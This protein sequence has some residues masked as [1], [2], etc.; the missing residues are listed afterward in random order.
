M[1]I[2]VLVNGN[3]PYFLPPHFREFFA[4]S[5]RLLR[6][7][8]KGQARWLIY[9]RT[10]F[11]LRAGWLGAGQNATVELAEADMTIPDAGFAGSG[12]TRD[13][14]VWAGSVSWP[15]LGPQYRGGPPGNRYVS[16]TGRLIARVHTGGIFAKI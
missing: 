3:V 4:V 10:N 2:G 6:A 12:T 14:S 8:T 9:F 11:K 7:R 15:E 16:G 5:A 1:V 13:N